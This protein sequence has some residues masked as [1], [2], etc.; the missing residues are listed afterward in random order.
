VAA[1]PSRTYGT[2][3]LPRHARIVK[4]HFAASAI[5]SNAGLEVPVVAVGKLGYPDLAELALRN[6]S[7]DMV[8]LGRPLL[9]DPEW[10]NKAYA[11]KLSGNTPCIGDQEGC[12]NELVEGG[13]LKCAVNPDTGFEVERSGWRSVPASHRKRIAVAGGGTA[14]IEAALTAVA[15][16][17]S[18][19]LYEARTE[20][21]GM[22]VPGSRPAIKY[23]VANYLE[24]L[25]A[26]L[27]RV[28][29]EGN[30]SIEHGVR[31][32]PGILKE[33][34]FDAIIT[35]TGSLQSRPRVPGIDG[36]S[37]VFAVDL[38]R[39][40]SIAMP[41]R[42]VV[43]IGGGTV[44][45]ETAYWLVDEL[46]KEVVIVETLPYLMKGVCTANRG[47]LLHFLEE[48]KVRIFNCTE[49]TSV[50][51]GEVAIRRNASGTVP[52]PFVTWAP[53]LPDNIPNPFERPILL[54]P[55]AETL[56]AD[57][58]V[59]AAGARPDDS[60]Y[61]ACLEAG[62]APELRN[63]GDSSRVGRVLEATSSGRAVGMAV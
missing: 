29:G 27:E 25:R 39:D 11:G 55:R 24:Y 40:P 63:V 12:L 16:G 48:R 26:E 62:T 37:V 53:V 5:R 1:A 61:L 36:R 32:N 17:H 46:G 2:W 51:T 52:D 49:L 7:C 23:E 59:L 21:G 18:V 3:R 33:G 19:V 31:A 6:G 44:G 34:R 60:L 10:P 45:C 38:L 56:P 30:L 28:A 20:T 9:A 14:G 8:M 54:E 22:L 15:R 47:W 42:R 35:A 58:V 41:A 43:I 13:H 57:L 4:E 50:G